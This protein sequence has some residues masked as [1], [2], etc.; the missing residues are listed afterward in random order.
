MYN[1]PICKQ[2]SLNSFYYNISLAKSKS[3][4]LSMFRNQVSFIISI[5][6]ICVILIFTKSNSGIR[7]LLSFNVKNKSYEQLPIQL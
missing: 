1:F 3:S 4:I 6:R 2:N 5:Y 7:A